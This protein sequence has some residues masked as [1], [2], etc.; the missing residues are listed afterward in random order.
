ER[1]RAHMRR[2]ALHETQG[3][4][5]KADADRR[6]AIRLFDAVIAGTRSDSLALLDRG[7]ALQPL[8]DRERALADFDETIRLDANNP[9]ALVARGTLLALRKEARKAITDFDRALAIAPQN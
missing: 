6:A 7:R 3:Q 1:A 8:G 2:A 9:S 5:P 4:G